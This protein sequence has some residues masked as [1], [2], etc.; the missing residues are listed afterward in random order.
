MENKKKI[1]M[2]DLWRAGHS[3]CSEVEMVMVH[4]EN[5]EW[6]RLKNDVQKE[7]RENKKRW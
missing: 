6:P 5:E 3:C 7:T 2:A 1:T 4:N